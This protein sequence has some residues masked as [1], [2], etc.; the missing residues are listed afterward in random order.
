MKHRYGSVG[1]RD[2]N[3][4]KR[5]TF[6]ALDEGWIEKGVEDTCRVINKH[7][8][9]TTVW[10][11]QGHGPYSKKNVPGNCHIVLALGAEALPLLDEFMEEL[12]GSE[13]AP[14]WLLSMC[15]LIYPDAPLETMY[16]VEDLT[17]KDTYNAWKISY[18]YTHTEPTLR[19][20]RKI[21]N[22]AAYKV[23]R[24]K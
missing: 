22:D 14:L 3:K 12:M 15:R 16:F 21:L 19:K 17:L 13:L 10:A 18:E 8:L 4:F 1:V 2:L 5:R 20:V 11:C 9:A 23:F 24:K 6:K 7:P